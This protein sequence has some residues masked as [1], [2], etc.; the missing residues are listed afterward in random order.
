VKKGYSHRAV[1]T[2]YLILA[3]LSAGCGLAY[4]YAGEPAS[5]F[6][7]V[8]ALTVMLALFFGVARVERK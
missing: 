2:L 7:L 5:A 8:L 6:A 4:W 1:T 3:I